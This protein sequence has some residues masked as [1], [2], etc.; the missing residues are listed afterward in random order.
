MKT[1]M[2]ELSIGAVL[3][4]IYFIRLLFLNADVKAFSIAQVQPMDELYYNELAVK[5]YKYGLSAL[6]DG[7]CSSPSVANARTFFIPNLLTA[8]SLKVFG[9]N[10]WGLK[11]PYILMGYCSGILLYI[12]LKS[13]IPEKKKVH[14]IIM[15]SYV[16]DFN[17]FMLSREAVT[18][19]PCMLACII[20]AMGIF[21]I[22]NVSAKWMFL[23]FWS[24]ISFCLVYMGLPFIFVA[25]GGLLVISVLFYHEQRIRKIVM[26]FIGL[27][28]GI[29]MSEIVSEVVFR[30][31]LI[32]TVKDTMTAHGGK[33]G[34]LSSLKS[35]GGLLSHFRA[36][37]ISNV[38][39]YNYLLLLLGMMTMFI[40][41]AATLLKKDKIACVLFVFIG[42]WWAQTVFLDNM[43]PSKSAITFPIVLLGIGYALSTYSYEFI[44][45]KGI[46]RKILLAVI[47]IFSIGALA[48]E[49]IA[50][51]GIKAC[52]RYGILIISLITALVMWVC[53]FLKNYKI[54]IIPWIFTLGIMCSMSFYYA[55]YNPTYADQALMEDLAKETS[56]GMIINGVG[57]S[58]YN[59]CESPA[60]IY[61][62]YKGQ[63]YDYNTM[64]QTMID[65]CYEYDDLY[66]IG[67]A[68]DNEWN[69]SGINEL[70]KDTPYEF[71]EVKVYLREYGFK[72]PGDHYFDEIL[73]KKVLREE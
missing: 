13:I 50:T 16:L 47:M 25:T 3:S 31:T 41:L 10:F 6:I 38:F 5:I 32:N 7:T 14:L 37:W 46:K 42:A 48:L 70:L 29:A 64:Y 51:N 43:T 71:V 65:A 73:Y 28:L 11:I 23:G 68:L 72:E 2:K 24:V 1:K 45:E 54:M 69:V 22:S 62:H 61:D 67:Y 19:M 53:I 57:F 60:S 21:K 49:Y 35:L 30:Q 44:V 34:G 9:N 15:V 40:L 52:F 59:L 33:I 17:I 18:V 27:V 56:D 12:L 66:Y 55:L 8:F 26:Y 20:T 63:G 39:K 58:L 36:Y 4:A